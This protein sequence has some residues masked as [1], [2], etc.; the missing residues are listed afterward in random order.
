MVCNLL[1]TA[2]APDRPGLVERLAAAIAAH[3]G[4]WQGSR[5]CRLGGQFAGIVQVQLPAEHRESLRRDLAAMAGAGLRVD[6]VEGGD[7]EP[8]PEWQPVRVELTAGDRPGVVRELTNAL[9]RIGINVEDLKSECRSAPMSGERLFYARVIVRPPEGCD[10]EK[11]R[12]ALE[13]LSDDIM[14]EVTSPTAA[15]SSQ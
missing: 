2:V 14:V 3:E 15:E 6:I 4:N 13:S 1:L 7:D 10:H 5:L 8:E 9:A 12:E 11:I